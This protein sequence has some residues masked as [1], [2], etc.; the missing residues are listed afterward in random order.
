MEKEESDKAG[1]GKLDS[2]NGL[3]EIDLLDE[4]DSSTEVVDLA[5]IASSD[6]SS[7]GTSS[8]TRNFRCQVDFGDKYPDIN[9]A[10][11]E[12]I[13]G[14]TSA[15]IGRDNERIPTAGEDSVCV[16]CCMRSETITFALGFI[17]TCVAIQKKKKKLLLIANILI[18]Y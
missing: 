7:L 14:L 17:R 16:V 13:S 9:L 15:D 5:D 18:C 1:A 10:E 6:R 8:R 2:S 4:E 12:L 3:R 11:L